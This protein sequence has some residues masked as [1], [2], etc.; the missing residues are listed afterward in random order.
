MQESAK[1]ALS[2]VRANC[3][4]LQISEDFID[5]TD[6]HIHLPEGAFPKTGLPRALPSRRRS[7][8]RCPGV[9]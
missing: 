8:R 3:E 4:A 7:Y 1:A 2:Y 6:I 9:P 5:N